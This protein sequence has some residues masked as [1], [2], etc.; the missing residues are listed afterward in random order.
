MVR[1]N[2]GFNVG[3]TFAS[4]TVSV[5]LSATIPPS[6]SR[7]VTVIRAEPLWNC[8]GV[9]VMVRFEL[10]PPKTI[11]LAGTREGLDEVAERIKLSSGDSAS[12]IVNPIG[13]VDPFWLVVR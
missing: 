7:T 11:S 9:I 2:S 6:R 8:A 13:P 10:D 12:L 1:L 4:V 5:K 3:G